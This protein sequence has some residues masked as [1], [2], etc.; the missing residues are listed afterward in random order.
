M[1]T[2]SRLKPGQVV[3]EVRH[4]HGTD[5]VTQVRIIEV[6][7]EE[8]WVL[9]T[10]GGRPARRYPPNKAKTWRINEPVT[11]PGLFGTRHLVKQKRGG[12]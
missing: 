10:W 7:P 9:A 5:S 4:H 1:A 12:Q 6:D 11:E 2:I 3:F 8:K